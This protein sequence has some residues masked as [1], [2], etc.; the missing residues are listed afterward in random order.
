MSILEERLEIKILKKICIKRVE[1]N[2]AISHK[3]YEFNYK[4]KKIRNEN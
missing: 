1:M 4:N 2:S 3:D